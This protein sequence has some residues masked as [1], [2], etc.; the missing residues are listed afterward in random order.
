M[1]KRKA[2]GETYISQ[3]RASGKMESPLGREGWEG[4]GHSGRAEKSL[5]AEE[6]QSSPSA[7]N[8]TTR[9][10]QETLPNMISL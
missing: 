4:A 10:I 2:V 7:D 5:P 6:T 1:L 9:A 3:R 8:S